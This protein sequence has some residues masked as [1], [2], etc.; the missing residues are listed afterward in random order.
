MYM[1]DPARMTIAELETEINLANGIINAAP[2]LQSDPIFMSRFRLCV[3]TL[4]TKQ[5]TQAEFEKI[6]VARENYDSPEMRHQRDMIA[7][8]QS[9]FSS[10]AMRDMRRER[11]AERA[12]M[13]QSE[14]E[15][16]ELQRRARQ[17]ANKRFHDRPWHG[18]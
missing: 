11:A 7:A 9:T 13:A 14:R 10:P 8:R 6:R 1:A 3:R 17:L 16:Q 5:K 18:P 2:S 12:I 4:A 15:S